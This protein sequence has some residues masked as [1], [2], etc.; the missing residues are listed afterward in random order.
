MQ[1]SDLLAALCLV[2]VIEG[3]MPFLAPSKYKEF[4]ASMH[5]LDEQSIRR[6]GLIMMIIGVVSLYFIKN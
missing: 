6:V 5:E 4:L 3:I 1:W 2:A